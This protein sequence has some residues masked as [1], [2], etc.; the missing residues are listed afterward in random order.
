MKAHLQYATIPDGPW[1]NCGVIRP[2]RGQDY[3]VKSV[4]ELDR[5][6]E[7]VLIGFEVNLQA[8]A[9]QLESDFLDNSAWY[10]RLY[11][12]NDT[13]RINLDQR[14]YIIDYD[15]QIQR[16][17]IEYH[18]ITLRFFLSVSE[19]ADFTTPSFETEYLVDD[20]D[21]GGAVYVEGS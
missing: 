21:G 14:S 5:I 8:V 1:K 15:G 6:D 10:F 13:K 11:Y 7:P 12:P 19:Y 18:T 20:M 4:S 2:K 3:Q 16:H 17:Q 9:L